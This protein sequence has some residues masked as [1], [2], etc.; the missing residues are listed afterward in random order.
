[1]LAHVN[2]IDGNSTIPRS[3]YRF[4]SKEKVELA[5]GEKMT[6]NKLSIRIFTSIQYVMKDRRADF[7]PF[8]LPKASKKGR[9]L[10]YY[11]HAIIKHVFLYPKLRDE[12]LAMQH[13]YFCIQNLNHHQCQR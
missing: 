1:M 13:A 9:E 8:A 12:V 11:A 5:S 3:L 2:R 4:E 6:I 10:H 7:D